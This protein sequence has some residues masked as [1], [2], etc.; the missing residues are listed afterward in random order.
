MRGGRYDRLC[1]VIAYRRGRT[2][3]I[4]IRIA[5]GARTSTIV[6]LVVGDGLGWALA[7]I[8]VGAGAVTLTRYLGRCSSASAAP[9]R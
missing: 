4:G 8:G 2:R 1:G 6:R 3:Q 9:I 7:G 5:L